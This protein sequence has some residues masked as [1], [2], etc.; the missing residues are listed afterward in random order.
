MNH[1]H[2]S[3]GF[4]KGTLAMSRLLPLS[5]SLLAALALL[6]VAGCGDDDADTPDAG[7]CAP[8]SAGCACLEGSMCAMGLMCD[9]G[10]CR[11]VDVIALEVGDA[12]ARSC[13][14]V[15]V[16]DRTQLLAVDFAAGTRGT[17]VREAPRTA[18]TFT[19]ETD[20]AFDD[21]AITI[22]RTEAAGAS[23]TLERGRCFDR[24]GNA[25][26]GSP[27]RVME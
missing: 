10:L 8:G 26:A 21:R 22:R 1:A 4:A 24:E 18:V 11:A 14:V 13:E 20:T 27:L 25:I 5:R 23:L 17:F 12:N 7:T 3:T 9:T 19:R 6:A 16:E 2:A 15:I